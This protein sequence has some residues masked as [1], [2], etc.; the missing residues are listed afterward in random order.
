MAA[1]MNLKL[2]CFCKNKQFLTALV[3]Q[4][5]SKF[6]R[7]LHSPSGKENLK[8]KPEISVDSEGFRRYVLKKKGQGSKFEKKRYGDVSLPPLTPRSAKM[9]VNQ[10]WTNVWP[11]AQTFKWSVVPLPLRQGA[12]KIP[13][14]AKG[15]GF[16]P[17]KYGN[18]ELLKIPNF[19]HLTPKH[20]EKHCKAIKKFCTSWPDDLSDR[21]RMKYHFPVEVITEDYLF[22]GPS[23]RDP[24]A[25][26]VTMKFRT[27]DLKLDKH[28]EDKFHRL[29]G[30]WENKVTLRADRCPTKR[31][32]YDYLQYLLTALY[33]E[34]WKV[35]PWES[36][37]TPED[38]KD[39][40]WDYSPN[41]KSVV[42][43]LN[44]YRQKYESNEDP[45]KEKQLPYLP[46]E[47][48]TVDTVN[49]LEPVTSYKQAVEELHNAGENITTINNY[50]DSV[51]K[52]LNI[53][54]KSPVL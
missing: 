48:I 16:P 1:P 30:S 28:A 19:L 14:E 3:A 54:R 15:D 32:N 13:S 53:Q 26:V 7:N 51:I 17:D 50:K 49:S 5:D 24:R 41:K 52:M 31:Q 25:R 23:V 33:F 46:D 45:N 29:V 27:G 20:I 22:A 6:D 10:D 12:L 9:P 43:L 40:A 2:R 39:F 18:T 47:E 44:I 35:E 8:E 38:F 42:E 34:S 36:E 37:I 4:H 21:R 11:A